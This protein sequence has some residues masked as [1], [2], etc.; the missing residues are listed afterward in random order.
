MHCEHS[1]NGNFATCQLELGCFGAGLGLVWDRL[2]FGLVVWGQVL[3]VGVFYDH[4]SVLW[5]D[6]KGLLGLHVW[7]GWVWGIMVTKQPL[8]LQN[9]PDWK[10]SDVT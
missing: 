4:Y 2:W 3:G 9:N 1:V 8:R 10:R 5:R 6:A 7:D